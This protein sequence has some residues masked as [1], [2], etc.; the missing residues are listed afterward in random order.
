MAPKFFSKEWCEAVAKN[1]NADEE[2]LA[3]AKGFTVKYLFIVTDTPQ[4]TDIK[5]LWDYNE[6]KVNFTHEEKQ[7][8]SGFRIGEEAWNDSI[9]LLKNQASYETL[10]K[11]YESLQ[12]YPEVKVEI[13]GYTD[14]RGSKEHNR[15]LSQGRAESV[16]Q[17]LVTKGIDPSRLKVKGYGPA[18]PIATNKTAAGRAKNRRIE[19]FRID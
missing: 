19:F 3:K 12:A 16:K 11:V 8:P 15:K 10:K 7:K 14:N 2:Y 5:V 4:D 1:A 18:D 13:R 6:G 17:Y 9:S